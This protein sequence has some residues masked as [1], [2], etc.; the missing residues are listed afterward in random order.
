MS[1]ETLLQQLAEY[2]IDEISP[3]QEAQIKRG[4]TLEV[5]G[6]EVKEPVTSARLV[7]KKMGVET[8]YGQRPEGYDGVVIKEPGGGGSVTIPYYIHEGQLYIGVVEE[9]RPT[10]TDGEQKKIL[11]VS[12]G[13]L[14]PG[15]THFETAVRELGEEAGYMPL[16][17]RVEELDGDPMNPNSSVFITGK[18]KGVRMYG[19]HVT[20][21]EVT[22]S[23]RS[24]DPT[25]REFKFNSDII[26]PATKMGEKISGSKFIH[27][28]QAVGQIDMFT[29][30]GIAR[31]LALLSKKG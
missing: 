28:K 1:Q 4:W 29:A 23:I 24:D 10:A 18:D 20:D 2:K 19:V 14:N 21:D 5:N 25:K 22:S 30:A 26:K 11:N 3:T 16:H 9:W 13:Y 7:N 17:E 31:I 8:T 6:Q 12:R 15:E 27:W